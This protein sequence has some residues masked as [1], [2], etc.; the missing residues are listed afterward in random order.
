MEVGIIFWVLLTNRKGNIFNCQYLLWNISMW[1]FGEVLATAEHEEAIII[2]E[3]D[4]SIL[5]QRRF[6]FIRMF[7]FWLSVIIIVLIAFITL[8]R[9]NLPVTKQRRGDLY[10]LVDFQRLNSQW[11]EQ[12]YCNW[13]IWIWIILYVALACHLC[14]M[15]IWMLH[16]C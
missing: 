5:E 6:S 8:F 14:Y 12:D 11:W 15:V 10:Q 3:I 1:Q 2:A 4:Y 7:C 13:D 9:T 16:Y